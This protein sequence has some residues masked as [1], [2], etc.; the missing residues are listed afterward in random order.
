MIL[1]AI[2]GR[3]L[4]V[5]DPVLFVVVGLIVL[6][7]FLVA[8]RLIA[9]FAGDELLKRHVRPD[10]VVLSRRIVTFVV[11]GLGL[12]AALAFA[13]ESANVA[14]AGLVLATILAALGVQDLLKDYVSG[15]YMLLERHIRVGDRISFDTHKGTV[16]EVRLRVTLLKSEE[17]DQ[18]I[19]PN[20]E[21]FTK[22]VTIRTSAPDDATTTPR[23]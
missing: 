23:T 9:R 11:I 12:F 5:S 13:F 2:G 20:S 4:P 10:I 7:A 1:A 3:S 16:S 19:V 17:G 6:A 8:S 14:L 18:I 15:Y 21:L 22:P